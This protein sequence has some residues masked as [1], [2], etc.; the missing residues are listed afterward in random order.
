[1]SEPYQ[2]SENLGLMMLRGMPG[3]YR[4]LVTVK[5]AP[6]YKPQFPTNNRLT[7]TIRTVFKR[8]KFSLSFD[9]KRLVLMIAARRAFSIS[10]RQR[11]IDA[12]DSV[13]KVEYTPLGPSD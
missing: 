10:E 8:K 3:N 9:E 11:L 2:C 5:W 12:I 1:M 4:Y 7:R 6:G 13:T